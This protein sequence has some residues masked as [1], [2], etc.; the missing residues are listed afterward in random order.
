MTENLKNRFGA[1]EGLNRKYGGGF[2][3][4]G[5]PLLFSVLEFPSP[6]KSYA[7]A[8]P[9]YEAGMHAAKISGA[10]VVKTPLASSYAHDVKAMLGAAPDAGLFYV[11]TPNNPTGTIT[12]HE[13]I[14]YMVE[15]KSKGSIVLVDE[16]Y[17]HFSDAATALDLVKADKDVIVLRTFSKIY[18]I[19]GLRCGLAIGRADLLSQVLRFRRWDQF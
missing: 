3:G 18:G 10:R 1:K 2:P 13:D 7:T 5:E 15:H 16:A 17:I 19:A 4:W 9:G 8:D 14:E 11:C 6:G 12:P